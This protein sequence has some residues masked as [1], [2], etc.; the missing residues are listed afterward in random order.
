MTE[1]DKKRLDD[2]CR[3]IFHPT[4]VPKEWIMAEAAKQRREAKAS[5]NHAE[6]LD[7]LVADPAIYPPSGETP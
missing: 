1:H 4:G 3:E 5:L 7:S 2:L 6:F